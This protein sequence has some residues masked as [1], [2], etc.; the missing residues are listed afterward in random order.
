MR[1][2]SNVARGE[3]DVTGYAGGDARA[4]CDHLYAISTALWSRLRDR[5]QSRRPAAP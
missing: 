4:H 2:T 3:L 5:W 1:P